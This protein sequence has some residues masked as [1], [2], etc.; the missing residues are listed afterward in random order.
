MHTLV[1]QISATA[2]LTHDFL[3]TA[4]ITLLDCWDCHAE[5]YTTIYNN[6]HWCRGIVTF[7][8][9]G[10]FGNVTESVN[11]R[12]CICNQ[13]RSDNLRGGFSFQRLG[14]RTAEWFWIGRESRKVTPNGTWPQDG[15][16]R[17]SS[18]VCVRL[19]MEEV[20][21]ARVPFGSR[22]RVMISREVENWPL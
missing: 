2:W 22:T 7:W 18:C 21:T 8:T 12:S 3:V 16:M 20:L 6:P 13:R 14:F 11:Q 10:W 4:Q 15:I 19:S 1:F 17:V 9:C 5:I